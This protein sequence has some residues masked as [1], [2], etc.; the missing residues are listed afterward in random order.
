[1]SGIKNYLK[2]Y[3]GLGSLMLVAF[4]VATLF[5]S[6]P[7]EAQTAH[8]IT[9]VKVGGR[10]LAAGGQ[11]NVYDFVP[12]VTGVTTSASTMTITLNPQGTGSAVVANVSADEDGEF[13]FTP[14]GML[15]AKG[16]ILN[17]TSRD[18]EGNLASFAGIVT[19]KQKHPNGSLI[20]KADDPTVYLMEGGK[21]RPIPS[22]TAFFSRN[23]DWPH[24][25][26]TS[27]DALSFYA[28]GSM[29]TIR[30]GALIKPDNDPTVYVVQ[31]STIR[32]FSSADI[33]LDLGYSWDS[34]Y[35][36]PAAEVATYTTGSLM[37]DDGKHLE[38]TPIKVADNATVYVLTDVGGTIKTRGIPTEAV[39]LS[40]GY[41]WSDIITVT[42]AQ[43]D[44]YASSDVL[45]FRD[46]T[47]VM[48]SGSAS[49]FVIE[50][51]KK[52]HFT[53]ADAFLGLGF[54]WSNIITIPAAELDAIDAG[55][56]IK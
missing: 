38:G 52:R 7:A 27:N 22:P 44:G 2:L 36:V 25:A 42:Q 40:H 33:F 19:L 34:I 4:F 54:S 8:S 55:T 21:K 39:Y 26:I 16:Y 35:T 56:D 13:S 17:I 45:S 14:G 32:P 28:T 24:I 9:K 3:L 15:D 41:R 18:D 49:V 51:N 23:Y 31:G 53:S 47:L 37:V 12:V 6:G 20:K 50:D 29:A 1:M 43:L 48:K 10:S 30:T 46:G 11:I 5:A